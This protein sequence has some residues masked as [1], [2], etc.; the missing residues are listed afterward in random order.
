[1][2]HEDEKFR[3]R[4]FPGN[5]REVIDKPPVPVPLPRGGGVGVAVPP[6]VIGDDAEALSRQALRTVKDVA[7]R[8]GDAVAADD[9]GAFPDGLTRELRG[10]PGRKGSWLKSGDGW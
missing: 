6:G 8:R 2:P 5:D 9:R 4:G 7:T 3:P 1:M 10:C